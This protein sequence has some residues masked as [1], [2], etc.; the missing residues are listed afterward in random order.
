MS[1]PECEFSEDLAAYALGALDE[2]AADA[3]ASHLQSCERCAAGLRR[4]RPALETL[5]ESVEQ[6]APPPELRERLLAT[7]RSEA[8]AEAEAAAG[9]RTDPGPARQ[10]WR[11]WRLRIGGLAFGPATALAALLIAVAVAVG[12]GIGGPGGGDRTRTLS[13]A[14]QAPGSLARLEL[15]GDSATLQAHNVPQ[16]PP[17]A[18]YQV[19]VQSG[20]AAPRASS[21][22][23]PS[24]DGTAAAAVPEALHGAD[25]LMV[26]REP[27]RGSRQPSSPPIYSAS[28]SN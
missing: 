4:L 14:S 8:E 19:W 27:G 13:V 17:G 22:F 7:V 11:Q 3:M 23:R 15:K 28:I 12:Y 18:V 2:G 5:P 24:A 10:G 26:T 25:R 6:L 9:P 21:M 1:A 16:L 20:D